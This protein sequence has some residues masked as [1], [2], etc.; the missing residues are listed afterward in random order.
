MAKEKIGVKAR[1]KFLIL[2]LTILLIG[3]G[4]VNSGYNSVLIFFSL[5][6]AVL[7]TSGIFSRWNL[8]GIEL[9]IHPPERIFCCQEAFFRLTLRNLTRIPKFAINLEIG[10]K[11]LFA[12]DIPPSGEAT[13]PVGYVFQK[14]GIFPFPQITLFSLFPL[15]MVLRRRIIHPRESFLVYPKV[16]EVYPHFPKEFSGQG[17]VSFQIRGAEEIAGLRE[18][19][20][21]ELRKI[22]W[23]ASARTGKLMEKLFA[24]SAGR[25][26]I[27]VLDP[28]GEG[29]KFEQSISLIASVGIYLMKNEIDHLMIAGRFRGRL[30]EKNLDDFLKALALIKPGGKEESLKLA[31]QLLKEFPGHSFFAAVSL[32]SSPL[33]EILKPKEMVFV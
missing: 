1:A 27:L 13:L 3:F 12:G 8:R 10:G 23:K 5:L 21:A 4:G 29:E 2:S 30:N 33:A 19:P 22:D 11:K 32:P 17:N 14:R 6:L 28:A 31:R 26:I 18:N 25:K 24:A 7:G 20:E 15:G 16:Y 9:E